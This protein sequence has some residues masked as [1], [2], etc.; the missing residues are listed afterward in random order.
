MDD[1]TTYALLA[2]SFFFVAVAF[3]L[4]IRYRQVS[5]RIN[6]STD[7]GHDLWSSL[8]QRLKKQDERILDMMGRLEVIQSRVLAVTT[9]PAPSA[10]VS[11]PSLPPAP[12]QPASTPEKRRDVAEKGPVVQQSTSRESQ[13]LQA[14]AQTPKVK[15]GL[16]ETQMGALKLLAEGPRNTRQLTD[17]LS[18][19]R[20]HMARVMKELFESGLVGRNDSSKPF[21]Y[22]LTEEG[23]RRL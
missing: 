1:L 21:V 19:S 2:T 6:A 12:T 10:A 18:V 13:M 22:Q 11:L 17:V 5:Q 15:E 3:G 9:S 4:M 20:E 7:L 23:R 8:E 14:N 16:D